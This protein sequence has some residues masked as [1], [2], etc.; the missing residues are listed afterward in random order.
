MCGWIHSPLRTYRH[1]IVIMMENHSYSAI[2]G[3]RGSSAYRAAPYTNGRLARGC[4][5]ATNYHSISHPSLPN[6]LALTSGSTHGIHTDCTSCAVLGPSIFSQL[7]RRWAAYQ[8]SMTS[9]CQGSSRALYAK[10]HN[11]PAYYT[12]LRAGCRLRDAPLGTL[13]AGP[14]SRALR[15][16]AL[17]AFTFITPN[18]CWDMHDCPV[19]VGDTWLRAWIPRLAS[20]RIYRRGRTAIFVV[21]DEGSGG[22]DGQRCLTS[23]RDQSCHVPLLV[24]SP[25]VPHGARAGGLYSHY[26]L[27]QTVERMLGIRRFLG[28]AAHALGMRRAFHL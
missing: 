26:S 14:L 20:S 4:G 11:P 6:Y 1:V 16:Q 21:W 13:R 15:L 18:L 2:I 10:H 22:R 19:T 17:P 5:L 24:I 3:R 27:L 7:P 12:A 28:G 8:Q 23:L 25:R 9:N